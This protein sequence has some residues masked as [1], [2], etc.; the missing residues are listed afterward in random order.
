MKLVSG[1]R[2]NHE[3]ARFAL[4][5]SG[6]FRYNCGAM[7]VYLLGF[8]FVILLPLAYGVLLAPLLREI[9]IRHPLPLGGVIGTLRK[10]LPAESAVE[11]EV[12]AEQVIDNGNNQTKPNVPA[13]QPLDAPASTEPTS[14]LAVDENVPT[15][16][17]GSVFD[18]ARSV[19]QNLSINQIIDL[20]TTEAP[21]GI[22]QDFEHRIDESA[23]PN[24]VLP[25]D[26]H[27]INDGMDADDLKELAAA[28]PKEKIDFT[29]AHEADS[30]VHD[31]I[32]P[33]AKE[34]LGENFDFKAI[35]SVSAKLAAIVAD[36]SAA[37]AGMPLAVQENEQGIIQ[38][39]SPVVLDVP[40]QLADLSTPQTILPTFSHDWIQETGLTVAVGSVEEDIA[41]FCFAEESRPMFYRKKK[42][43]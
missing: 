20:M 22:P 29:Q 7:N 11:K 26:V 43:N 30:P 13:S 5:H 34:V 8:L 32:S 14:S 6:F 35:E 37:P 2:K 21:A 23:R 18:G 40:P 41:K 24:I 10:P 1:L 9:H 38:V 28:L 4:E 25:P 42:S 15:H 17:S 12:V 33:M 39:S 36:N 27:G 16:P 31:A 19:S 3:P